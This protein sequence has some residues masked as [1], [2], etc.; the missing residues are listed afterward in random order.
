[1]SCP[2]HQVKVGG[3]NV[4]VW[5]REGKTRDGKEFVSTSISITKPYQ[6]DGKWVNGTNYDINDIPK[7]Q[8]A[9]DEVFKWRYLKDQPTVET[10]ESDSIP[11]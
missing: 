10:G 2:V 3:I 8:L 4:A 11:F 6:K 5:E 9:L 7:I 1:M